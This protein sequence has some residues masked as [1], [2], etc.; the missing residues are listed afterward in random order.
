VPGF[1]YRTNGGRADLLKGVDDKRNLSQGW[2]Q[3]FKEALQ[4][5]SAFRVLVFEHSDDSA[6]NPHTRMKLLWNRR[7]EARN[8]PNIDWQ[9]KIHRGILGA[10][11]IFLRP[12]KTKV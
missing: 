10:S 12:R 5:Y 9:D 6:V 2:V 7:R 11:E 1:K 3:F 8:R 4:G